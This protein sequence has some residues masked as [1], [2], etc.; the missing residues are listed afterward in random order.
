MSLVHAEYLKISRR[1][2]FP[3]TLLAVGLLMAMTAF[4]ATVFAELMPEMGGFAIEKPEAYA[5]GAQQAASFTWLPLVLTVAV[6]GGE[7][8]TTVWATSLTRNPNRVAHI[9]ARLL[10]FTAASWMAFVFGAA[11]FAGI[12]A[13]AGSGSG[14][15]EVSEWLGYLWRFAAVAVAWTSLGLGAVALMRSTVL[16]L[17]ATIGFSFVDSVVATF[18]D[19]YESFSLSAAS[20]GMF[21]GGL[22]G[23]PFAAL[24]PGADLTTGQS[25]AIVAGWT[26]FGF[27]MTWWG[28]QR[29]DA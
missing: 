21:E 9:G 12:V 3:L 26:L 27:L 2:I 13:F 6:V 23:G 18:V 19:A 25:L 5:F 28:L 17:V 29:R 11:V 1:K 15:P 16:A 7:F 22:L 8:S 20:T 24:V 14:A 10:I 4:F